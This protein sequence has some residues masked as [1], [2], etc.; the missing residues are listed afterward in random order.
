MFKRVENELELAMFNGIWTTVWME[1][2]FELEFSKE[3][4]ERFIV[5]TEEG[6]YVGTSEIKSYQPEESLMN[7]VAPFR[8]HPDIAA[9]PETVAEIDKIALLKPYRGRYVCD[10]LSS[11]ICYAEQQGI[12]YY[13]A[14]ME[15][16]FLR[17]LRI[18]YKVPYEKLGN[19]QYY[20]GDY[21]IPVLLRV[22]EIYSNK[23]H[24]SWLISPQ[25]TA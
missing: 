3:V 14:L 12:R 8:E 20:K 5:V 11:T 18:T 15:P 21:I 24:Y 6:H 17:A 10:L 9:A 7:E 23:Q 19:K 25:P 16:V 2:G 13:V 1:K 4:L 22:E